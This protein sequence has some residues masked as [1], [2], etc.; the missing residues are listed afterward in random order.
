[1]RRRG[2]QLSILLGAGVFFL[3]AFLVS[4]RE[5]VADLIHALRTGYWFEW[6]PEG[7]APDPQA[8]NI[9]NDAGDLAVDTFMG[10]WRTLETRAG[11]WSTKEKGLRLLG[12]LA[13]RSPSTHSYAINDRGWILGTISDP[14]FGLPVFQQPFLWTP[15]TGIVELPCLSA[16]GEITPADINVRGE[17]V[18]SATGTSGRMRAF[19][20][21]IGSGMRDLGALSDD[22]ESFG[23]A[24]NDQ[25]W[26]VGNARDAQEV[27]GPV[28]WKPGAG[29]RSLGAF[30][31]AAH[32]FA[33]DINNHGGVLVNVTVAG[34]PS[35]TRLAGP[36]IWT[37]ERGYEEV[38][39]PSGREAMGICINDSGAIL[40]SVAKEEAPTY[41]LVSGSDV[42]ELPAA[43]K[44]FRTRYSSLNNRGWLAGW[45]MLDEE[46]KNPSS[47]RG[48]L[49]KPR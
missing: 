42:K 40:L 25:G 2:R 47:V 14:P 43:R 11:K 30:P 17:V 21:E 49:A 36:V 9:L 8:K 3:T 35:G 39:L 32:S 13:G 41:F 24:I 48:F 27:V 10:E 19:S 33:Q 18:G 15:E 45:V 29:M 6:L 4:E 44:G 22:G 5:Q 38:A 20:W 37:E 12:V 31:G 1:V 23:A 7:V 34:S 26:I 46:P 28:L 16:K